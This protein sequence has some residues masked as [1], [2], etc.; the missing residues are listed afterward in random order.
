MEYNYDLIVI[1]SGPGGYVSAIKASKL[2]MKV[3]I[4]EGDEIGGTC[5]NRGCIP[6]KSLLHSS[7]L[8]HMLKNT[9][10]YG[11]FVKDVSFELNKIIVR[12]DKVVTTTREGIV[13]LLNGNK[14]KITKGFATIIN[15]NTVLVNKKESITGKNILIATGAIPLIPNIIG[16][17][18]KDVVTSDELL[19]KKDKL[20]NH[21]LIIGGGVIGVE[22]ATIYKELGSEVT[23]IE[24]MERILPTMDREISTTI[25]MSLKKKGVTILPKAKV[26]EIK[27]VDNLH[28]EYEIGEKKETIVA[29]GI[30]IATG[31]KAYTK[32]LFEDG[33]QLDMD[34]NFIKVDSNFQT[35]EKGI[36]AIGDVTRGKQLAHV[37]SAQGI[38][39]V[40][41]MCNKVS[42]INLNV[43]PSCIYTN[44]EVAVVG[45]SKD[46]AKEMGIEVKVGKYPLHGNCKTMISGD[47]RGYI[48]VILHAD[49][50]H[51]IGGEIVCARATDMIGELALAIT[52]GMKGDDIGKIIR[53]HPTYYEGIAEAIE[54][55][56]GM[57]IHML[58][59]KL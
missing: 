16:H 1:G 44:P 15:N 29:D 26:S 30:L 46:E 38:V 35:S 56:S 42:T 21:L 51:I 24:S 57:A 10:E 53:A 50:N 58:P 18:L 41:H 32:G 54:D 34:G 39:A 33:F 22:F 11:V 19:S 4:I 40:D 55:I 20:Y 25:S 12:K 9:E 52:S 59:K 2:G 8:Y 31:R 27:K 7:N 47:E 14:V 6:T 45:I 17:D 48:K 36:Y 23:I 37:A 43:V 49:T 3:I 28:C 5:L 13:S